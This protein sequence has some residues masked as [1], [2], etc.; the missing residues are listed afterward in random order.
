MARILAAIS[1]MLSKRQVTPIS[2]N[3]RLIVSDYSDADASPSSRTCSTDTFFSQ[4]SEFREFDAPISI[5]S[6]VSPLSMPTTTSDR[7]PVP[8]GSF[9][10]D[11]SKMAFGHLRSK[12]VYADCWLVGNRDDLEKIEEYRTPS[13]GVMIGL[14]TDG[15]TEYNLVPN[16]YSY[17]DEVNRVVETTIN[18]IREKYRNEGGRLDRGGVLSAARGILMDSSDTLERAYGN[19]GDLFE[20]M[21]EEI[22]DTVYRYTMGLG[23]FD[24]L[25]ADPKLEDIYI[26]A[27]CEKNRIHVTM[28]G[29]TGVNSHIRCRTNLTVDK[30]EVMNLINVLKRESGLQF[31]ESNPVL[32]TDMSTHDARATVVGYPMSPNGDAVAIRKHSVR[33]WTLS[34]LIANGTVDPKIAGLLSFLVDN[35]ATFLICGPRG[36]GKSSLLSAMMFEFPVSQRILT[37]EDT[38]ELPGSKMRRMGYKVQ[39]MLIDDRMTG[40]S[41]SRADE[42]LR[43]SLRMGESAI[44]LGE[45]RG[46]EARTL[47]QSMR[48][49]RAGSSILG[50]IHGDSARSVFER[51]VH[52]MNIAPEA[53]MATDVLMTL[54]TVRDRRSGN[55]IRRMNEIVSTGDNPGEFLNLTDSGTLFSSP[56]MRRIMSTSQMTKPEIMKEIRARAL[57]RAY[58]ADA[59]KKCGEKYHGPEWIMSANEHVSKQHGGTAE[60]VLQSFRDK[61][62]KSTGADL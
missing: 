12:P 52:D 37:I 36:A 45:V 50:T 28:G 41:L 47:Y 20:S 29:I 54:G 24:I 53:F 19:D 51:V 25:L 3:D 8:R 1:D 11:L 18:G 22:C 57:I 33:P 7:V 56:V 10:D 49:G 46:E 34:R 38:I 27:P 31:C 16:E 5:P 26:D 32:E 55:Q 14:S 43:V 58:L 4:P 61:F 21:A 30:K 60:D 39:S 6:S 23:V 15:E 40:D 62:R 2:Y 35:R 48:T 44:V 13:G 59:G 9:M 42:A 17:P